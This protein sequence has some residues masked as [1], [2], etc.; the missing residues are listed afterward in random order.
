MIKTFLGGAV[1]SGL[2]GAS[3]AFACPDGQFESHVTRRQPVE[4]IPEGAVQLQVHAPF[5][6]DALRRL[7][8]FEISL[9][10]ERV[11]DGRFDA[12]S[13]DLR[14]KNFSSCDHFGPTG[15]NIY[16]VI[17]PILYSEGDLD[18]RGKPIF[19]I[20]RYTAASDFD[21]SGNA[22]M[23]EFNE[24]ARPNESAQRHSCWRRGGHTE[25]AA[26]SCANATHPGNMYLGTNKLIGAL[27]T[28]FFSVATAGLLLWRQRAAG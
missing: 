25:E 9:E 12:D 17:F 23:H 26:V 28:V 4:N 21:Y 27:A 22:S 11:I 15:R 20:I 5:E 10:I 6:E 18:E 1:A 19:E 7:E 24:W 8:D 3:P 16:V 13:V 14:I 2:I